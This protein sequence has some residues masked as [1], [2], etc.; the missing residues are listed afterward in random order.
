MEIFGTATIF[1][2]CVAGLA[3]I[4]YIGD[5][6]MKWQFTLCAVYINRNYYPTIIILPL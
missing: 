3:D 1:R 6:P 5:Q 4:F 2:Q